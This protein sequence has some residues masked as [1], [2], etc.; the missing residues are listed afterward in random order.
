MPTGW[1][2][3]RAYRKK[4]NTP[5]KAATPAPATPLASSLTAAPVNS[6]TPL[7]VALAFVP[8]DAPLAVG[9]AVVMAAGTSPTLVVAWGAIPDS[10]ETGIA[11]TAVLVMKDT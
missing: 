2:D 4:A 8:L 7:D 1:Q 6:T 3:K 11:G 5:A 9:L 10:F